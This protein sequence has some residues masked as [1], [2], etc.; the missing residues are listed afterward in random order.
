MC[1]KSD[2]YTSEAERPLAGQNCSSNWPRSRPTL[3]AVMDGL[4]RASVREITKL[5]QE[6]VNDYMVQLTDFENSDGVWIKAGTMRRCNQWRCRINYVDAKNVR[7]FEKPKTKL[8][9][10]ERSSNASGS[11]DFHKCK[12]LSH[13]ISTGGQICTGINQASMLIKMH[14][15]IQPSNGSVT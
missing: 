15:P 6:T 4:I 14:F 8:A 5:L 3:T 9:A 12:A 11:S 1:S 7:W 2:F 10:P 13:Q